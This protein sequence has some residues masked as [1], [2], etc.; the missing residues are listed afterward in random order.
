MKIQVD[1]KEKTVAILEDTN[2]KELIKV[3]KGMLGEEY[4]VY[5][6]KSGTV[7]WY[8]YPTYTWTTG[9][10]VPVTTTTAVYNVEVLN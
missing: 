6:V 10:T 8:Y 7:Y 9:D 3:L 1:T 5:K 4:S 2:I